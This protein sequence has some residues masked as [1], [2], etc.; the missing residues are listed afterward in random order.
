MSVTISS[1]S[2]GVKYFRKLTR[3]YPEGLLITGAP[4]SGKSTVCRICQDT[5]VFVT[6]LDDYLTTGLLPGSPNEG[7]FIEWK[8]IPQT[9]NILCG[10]ASNILDFNHFFRR[11]R[12]VIVILEVLAPVFRETMKRRTVLG[13]Y[14]MNLRQQ[15]A[16]YAGLSRTGIK[17]MYQQFRLVIQKHLLLNTQ[18][19]VL[20][21]MNIPRRNLLAYEGR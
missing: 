13:N 11:P 21:T 6:D 3:T 14:P 15:Y 2:E 1:V 8:A 18:S 16:T 17:Q 9:R 20:V 12:A 4:C 5:D 10:Y 7:L 19:L